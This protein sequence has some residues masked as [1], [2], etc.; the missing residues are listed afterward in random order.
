MLSVILN[1]LWARKRR[2]VGMLSAVVLGVGFL[3]GALALGDTL[4]ANFNQLFTQANAGTDVVVRA[5]AGVGTGLD[6]SRP[7]IPQSLVGT[8]KAVPGVADAQPSITGSGQIIGSDGQVVGGLGPPRTAGAWI[9]DPALTPYRLVEG[10][11]PAT[12]AEVVINKGA[13]L[14]G[15][16]RLG[17]EIIVE[18]PA[19]VRVRIVGI[20]TFGNANG[21]GQATY[22]G[23]TLSGAQRYL[24][25][26]PGSVSSI[27]VRAGA[28]ATQPE[29]AARIA[30]ALPGNL[31][32]LTGAVVTQQTIAD[33]TGGFLSALRTLLVIFAA[34]A[35]LVATFSIVNTFSILMAQR[36]REQALLRS[37]G[38]TRRQL[39]ASVLAEAL[40]L[41]IAA[42]GLGLLCGV[43]IAGLLKGVF[44]S[45]GFA[46][47]AG[48]LVISATTVIASV[49]VGIGVT[50]GAGLVPALR[51]A[52]I[53]P[54]AALRSAAVET[55]PSLHRPLM[56]G[57]GFAAVGAI[58]LAAGV[59]APA[60]GVRWVGLGALLVTVAVVVL[61][62]VAARAVAGWI[63]GPFESLRGMPG[64]LARE[65]ARRNPRRTAAAATALMVGVAVVSLFTVFA[66]SIS[67][68]STAGLGDAFR[69]DIAVVAGG[70]G[71][72]GVNPQLAPALAALPGI[73][74]VSGIGTGQALIG[75]LAEQVSVVDPSTLP[76]VLDL[77]PTSGSLAA[78]QPNQLAVSQ[79]EAAKRG[80]HT[81]SSVPVVLPDG[82]RQ[83]LRVGA[84]YSSRVLT[85]DYLLPQ[86]LWAPHA[87]Q[88]LDAEI[89]VALPKGVAVG[90]E[91]A[92]VRHAAASYGQPAV[93]DRATYL[94]K[95][96]SS[97]NVVLG[98]V[99]VLL[100]LAIA[101]AVLGIA[102]TL[103]LA[104]HERT[105][106]I[107]LLRAVGQTRR[108]LRTM[109]RLESVVVALFGAAGG[110]GLGLVLG[111]ALAEAAGQSDGLTKLSVPVPQLVVILALGAVAGVLAAIR[112]ARRA[113][114]LPLLGA[115][116][117]E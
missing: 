93:Q 88:T 57:S 89:Y 96:G 107:G 35:L 87:L 1:G 114:R 108:Q 102:N 115:I 24:T 80:W 44:D 106:E 41:G 52:R 4:S 42:S 83:R 85:G 46:L 22:A 72:G 79:A 8:I 6:A 15:H 103:S 73:G 49:V 54:I 2:L 99:Y 39:L 66:R 97:I 109:I 110:V 98:I 38:A 34:I 56:V 94:A 9:P 78:L 37:L 31:Q 75:G 117:A 13:G 11:A 90:P 100:A 50:V 45:F 40:A 111:L 3:A 113:A 70:F 27:L 7:L 58:L 55:T 61:G 104:V 112:P 69:G 30:R 64:A 32:V 21:F 60:N 10:R 59:T 14:S 33:L 47:P 25:G 16:L 82:T 18:T 53:P 95:A 101:I 67:S 92:A 36:S 19:G 17:Q 48:G 29:L 51:A 65:N 63:G 12:D 23:F 84:L 26:R 116:A 91:L 68:A 77:G 74:T 76:A 43:A 81:G 20:V 5:P 62:P 86:A 71:P 28:G 105:R